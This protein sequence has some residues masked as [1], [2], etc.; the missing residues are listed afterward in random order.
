M[1][2][3]LSAKVQRFITRHV[4]SLLSSAAQVT[5][6]RPFVTVIHRSLATGQP[7]RG[8]NRF[9]T[10]LTAQVRSFASPYW[11]TLRQVVERG[12][13]VRRDEMRRYTPLVFWKRISWRKDGGDRS[14]L[15]PAKFIKIWHVEQTTLAA[16][17]NPTPAP[18]ASPLEAI[19]RV[20]LGLP[21]KPVILPGDKALYRPGDD[22]VFLPD[23]S[24]FP[25]PVAAAGT[26]LHELAH[27]T[28]HPTR[29]NRRTL[30][31]AH[32]FG[33]PDYS[34][35]EITVELAT[36]W[37]MAHIGMNQGGIRNSAAYIKSWAKILKDDSRA[38]F[39]LAGQSQKIY[40]YLIRKSE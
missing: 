31:E 33:S 17:P 9:L 13:R 25:S 12:G 8:V 2:A 34:E 16:P 32:P 37:I 30:R 10:G 15:L 14:C 4:L 21:E 40:N 36:S 27:R 20:I 24:S 3:R 7:Y 11:L 23:A 28:G 39:R 19:R 6:D 18:R 22:V 38:V 5:A 29:L 1:E 26:F 35:E